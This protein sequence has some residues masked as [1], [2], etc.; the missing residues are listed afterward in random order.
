MSV[1]SRALTLPEPPL[2]WPV[3]RGE[4]RLNAWHS[5]ANILDT[6]SLSS[7]PVVR[8]G[9]H[10]CPS[11][12]ERQRRRYAEKSKT[13]IAFRH[14][15]CPIDFSETAT[16]ALAYATA[17]A[18]WY[19]AQ[20]TVVHVVPV[21]DESMES[22]LPLV[23]DERRTPYAP[24]RADVLAEMRRVTEQVGAAALNPALLAEEGRTHAVIVSRAASEQADLLVLG[25]HGR[26][27]FNRLLLGS[28]AEKVMRTAPCPVL[29]VP[30]SVPPM[31]PAPITFKKIL[32]PIDFAPS[33][34][35]AFA[36]AL[37]LGRQANGCVTVL[38]ALEH[39]D[40]EEPNEHVDASVRDHR[41]Q[42]IDGARQRL[43]A[44]VSEESRSWC[45]IDEIVTIDRAHKA[46][47]HRAAT[48]GTDLIVMGAQGR[49]VVELMLYG[50]STQHVVRAATCP[51]L[52]VRA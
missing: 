21:F 23:K 2:A 51:V 44:L 7:E 42:V 39:M 35:K 32:C 29:T 31:T 12:F 17:L 43:H 49:G 38:H 26:G 5:D 16:R 47:L 6:A 11:R 8:S 24:I 36:Y 13:V 22:S 50:S 46:T 25:T 15:V 4:P 33:S 28:V 10:L 19:E 9:P 48:V 34:L 41:Q 40:D 20:L 18:K 30:P 3:G 27:G 1:R 14:L 52:T 37:D 45:D